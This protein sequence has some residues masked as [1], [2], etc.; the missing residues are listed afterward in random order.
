MSDS[1]GNISEDL[2]FDYDDDE[3]VSFSEFTADENEIDLVNKFE[4]EVYIKKDLKKEA[5]SANRLQAR[6]KYK[7]W[8]LEEYIN[9]FFISKCKKLQSM[10]LPNCDFDDILIMLHAKNWGE[11]SVIN[12]CYDNPT[13]FFEDCGLPLRKRNNTFEVV[14]NFLCPICCSDDDI[15]TETY[16]LTCNHKF[17]VA[18]YTRYV[19]GLVHEGKLITCPECKLSIP[20]GDVQKFVNV[21]NEQQQSG[22][23]VLNSPFKFVVDDASK[24]FVKGSPIKTTIDLSSF[25]LLKY[26]AKRNIDSNP[27]NF[28]YCP[29]P[30]CM[31]L[32]ELLSPAKDGRTESENGKTMDE[33]NIYKVP[34]VTCPKSHEFCY[35]CQFENHLPL[36]C[37]LVKAWIKKCNDDSETAN[38]IDA[39]TQ[40]CPKCD[41]QIEKNGGCNHMTC[42]T[43]A[44]HFCWICLEEWAKHGH[45]YY[46][47]NRFDPDTVNA[48]QKYKKSKRLTLKRYIFFYSRFSVHETS[49]EGD[50][51]TLKKVNEKMTKYMNEESKRRNNAEVSSTNSLSWI[52][53]QF[54]HDAIRQLTNGRKTL[55][56]TYVF[57][58]YLSKSN[59][60]E[61]FEQMQDYLNKTVEDLSKIFEEIYAKKKDSSNLIMQNKLDIINLSNLVAQRQEKMIE[62]AFTGLEQKLLRLEEEKPESSLE[63]VQT[64][65]QGQT[66]RKQR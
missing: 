47:C 58:F 33:E 42:S 66:K 57:A 38:W 60:S 55:K 62:F 22:S 45:Q 25:E 48:A 63:P 52:D 11:E 50:S 65:T 7:A 16:S 30:D 6:A 56:W 31:H 35:S 49:M 20:H 8:S 15:Q 54:L 21:Y 29:A 36:P 27:G 26:A 39:H 18:C 34:I 43:C 41:S 1:D 10:K 2:E 64:Q 23:S 53:V 24:A 5:P 44:Y 37:W 61:I 4:E 32:V 17:C 59:F 12:G 40:S 9:H 51:K 28:K 3:E 13:K 46:A 19:V 14:K